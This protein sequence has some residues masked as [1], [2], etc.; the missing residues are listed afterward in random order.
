MSYEECDD[1]N[2]ING[3]GCSS[4]CTVEENWSCQDGSP[5]NKDTCNCSSRTGVYQ[6]GN[7]CVILETG[8]Q[9]TVAEV[10]TYTTI[11]SSSVEGSLFGAQLLSGVSSSMFAT[12][13]NYLHVLMML[14]YCNVGFPPI[15]EQLFISLSNE[16]SSSS[17][18]IFNIFSRLEE[19]YAKGGET[20]GRFHQFGIKAFFLSNIGYFFLTLPILS[21]VI[22]LLKILKR[23]CKEGTAHRMISRTILPIF[24]WN[25]TLSMIISAQVKLSFGWLVQFSNPFGNTYSVINFV[26]AIV[27]LVAICATYIAVAF[28]ISWNWSIMKEKPF[29]SRQVLANALMKR[30]KLSMLWKTYDIKS[31]IGRYFL[32]IQTLKTTLVVAIIFGLYDYPLAQCYL[33]VFLSILYL[34]ILGIGRPFKNFV[35]LL[36]A[37]GNEICLFLEEVLMA[38]F[39][40]N[41]QHNFLDL[42]T[43]N[44]LGWV[45]IGVLFLCLA[46]NIICIL[47]AVIYSGV[48]ALR[49]KRKKRQ[50]RKA[51]IQRHVKSPQVS[52]NSLR[53]IDV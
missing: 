7:N 29:L 45:M 11:T 3:D 9:Q 15:V 51:A 4:K 18:D 40:T 22:L 2:L 27:T 17:T 36:D 37:I 12:A 47:A 10:T 21:F 14:K 39:A 8:L 6:F 20:R 44:I 19:E 48:E 23:I 26:I 49:K 25:M 35:D 13:L 31:S 28:K 32:I 52:E 33:L 50:R 24:Q 16:T 38:V 42:R 53:I 34:V 43:G 30:E 46:S 41:K 5:T 1:G